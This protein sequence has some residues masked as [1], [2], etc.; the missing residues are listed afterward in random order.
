[1]PSQL[2]LEEDISVICIAVLQ[3][4]FLN[5]IYIVASSTLSGI[6]TFFLV[7]F[8]ERIF[9]NRTHLMSLFEFNKELAKLYL[10][11]ISYI[12]FCINGIEFSSFIVITDGIPQIIKL[13]FGYFLYAESVFK[14]FYCKICVIPKS[15]IP[16]IWYLNNNLVIA[17]Y[18]YFTQ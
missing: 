7:I 3:C 1:M 11:F 6:T 16:F 4:T 15:I 8:E 14:V 5:I 13:F 18:A 17:I 2:I 10:S 9:L 12:P